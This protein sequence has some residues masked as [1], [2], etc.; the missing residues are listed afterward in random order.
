MRRRSE[1]PEAVY[2]FRHALIRDA[3]Q[4][5]L[6][7]E[8]RREL[9]ARAADAIEKLQ[10]EAAEREPEVLAHHRAEAGEAE[11]AAALYLRAG[12][13]AAERA[14]FREA[15]AHL[16]GALALLPG[17]AD[18]MTARRLE[19]GLRTALGHVAIL[20][21]GLGSAAAGR[22]LGH[23]VQLCRGL[24]DD[25]FLAQTLRVLGAHSLFT[26]DSARAQQF[27][28]EA[29]E[30]TRRQGASERRRET[31]VGLGIIHYLRG[32]SDLAQPVLEAVAAGPE[33]TTQARGLCPRAASPKL[34]S[35]GCWRNSARRSGRPPTCPRRWS[36]RA[37]AGTSPP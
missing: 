29:V 4:G 21:E 20:E 23:A 13:R 18:E 17:M 19:A 8:R 14:A 5:T 2:A 22:A 1:P 16:T 37:E 33:V 28:E 26:G 25:A 35:R 9:H 10:P 27:L 6:L 36:G 24:G 12:E 3:A 32:R 15:R 7:R 30:I 31:S 34:S 11:M